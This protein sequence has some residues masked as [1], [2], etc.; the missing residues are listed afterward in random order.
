MGL[1]HRYYKVSQHVSCLVLNILISMRYVAAYCLAALG[2][3]T[4]SAKDIEKILSSVGVDC[5]AAKAGKVISE[6][7]GKDLQ[8]VIAEGMEKVG[9]MPVG[10]GGGGGAAGGA[11][12]A[13]AEE[14]K[15]EKLKS[16]EE[17]SDDDM[18]F[19]LF[20]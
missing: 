7:E 19:G 10:G 9:S 1:L 11:A 15:E 3:A 2:G 17:E 5:D 16:P 20:D 13:A 6:L 12:P 14:K 4:P 18:G 8:A